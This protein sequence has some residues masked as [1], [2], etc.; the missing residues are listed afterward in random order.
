VPWE[1]TVNSYL[2]DELKEFDAAKNYP[3]YWAWY[4]SLV[5]R[6]SVKKAYNL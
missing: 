1:F 4:Q 2:A 3:N 5:A 6:P